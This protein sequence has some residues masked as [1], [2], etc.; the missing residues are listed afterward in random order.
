VCEAQ[1]CCG[2]PGPRRPSLST[3]GP[4]HC[5]AR[6]CAVQDRGGQVWWRC[7]WPVPQPH[8]QACKSFGTLQLRRVMC[9]AA[10]IVL[11]V[12][13]AEVSS[14]VNLAG[15]GVVWVGLQ[16]S[17]NQEGAMSCWS[18]AA[19]YE[20]ARQCMLLAGPCLRSSQAHPPCC[21]VRQLIRGQSCCELPDLAG[22]RFWTKAVTLSEPVVACCLPD[23]GCGAARPNLRVVSSAGDSPVLSY[24]T[25]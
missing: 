2:C 11:R 10:H 16:T 23:P 22:L 7:S 19:A 5:A 20:R 6:C 14:T 15:V 24:Q 3:L 13:G 9:F 4:G 21:H 18:K 8:I 17:R 12:P 25:W 1:C